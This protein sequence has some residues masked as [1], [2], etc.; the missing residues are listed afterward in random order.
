MVLG[1]R[2]GGEGDSGKAQGGDEVLEGGGGEAQVNQGPQGHVAADA[3]EA[4]E[5]GPGLARWQ[6][7]GPPRARPHPSGGRGDS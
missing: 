2:V 3:G 7:S 4:I 1:D 6:G 5:K